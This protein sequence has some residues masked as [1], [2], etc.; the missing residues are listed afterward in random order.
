MCAPESA[1]PMRAAGSLIMW[2]TSSG[3]WF[4]IV[5]RQRSF[6]PWA[7]TRS[8]NASTGWIPRASATS[9]NERPTVS[10]SGHATMWASWKS[11]CQTRGLHFFS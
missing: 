11:R 3:R 1:N 4:A 2:A 10:S 5:V 7:T 6:F 8:R 9:P